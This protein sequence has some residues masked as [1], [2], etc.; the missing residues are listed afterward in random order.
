MML[1][2][3]S[4]VHRSQ[5][6]FDSLSSLPLKSLMFLQTNP[7]HTISR[8]QSCRWIDF[9]SGVCSGK[10]IIPF[11]LRIFTK[12][13]CLVLVLLGTWRS[14]CSRFKSFCSQ[15]LDSCNTYDIKKVCII[16]NLMI[17]KCF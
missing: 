6:H 3:S 7:C 2:A 13:F 14:S 4:S 10:M 1:Q 17:V 11:S 5:Y 12:G 9:L 8:P 16:L 15:V